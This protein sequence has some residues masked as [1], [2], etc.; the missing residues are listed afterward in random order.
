MTGERRLDE[1]AEKGS[2][3]RVLKP[4]GQ[5]KLVSRTLIGKDQDFVRGRELSLEAKKEGEPRANSHILTNGSQERLKALRTL[6][7]PAA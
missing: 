5:I 7:K 1:N 6:R 4:P 3:A 2:R